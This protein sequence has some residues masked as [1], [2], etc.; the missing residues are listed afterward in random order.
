MAIT[1]TGSTLSVT[2]SNATDLELG[3]HLTWSAD[4][5]KD[6]GASGANRPR[7]GYFGTSV[8]SPLVT[9]AG[10]L[11]LSA[12]GANPITFSSGGTE[13]FRLAPTTR[14]LL[15]GT[16][17]DGNYRLDVQSS[18][19]SGTLRVYDQTAITGSTSL[20]VRAGAGQST[21]ELLKLQN[22]SG[23]D[24]LQAYNDGSG[25]RVN[26]KSPDLAVGLMAY[27]SNSATYLGAYSNHPV[28]FIAN[29]AEKFRLDGTG[30]GFFGVTPVARQTATDLATLLTAMQ[31]LGLIN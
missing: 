27:A 11:A 17:T 31:N 1:V 14:N 2:L 18:G 13:G 22:G 7:T 6:V 12:T 10:T 26:L 5:T 29:N 24:W 8:V 23:N 15:I 16:T 28:I 21:N 25:Y 3:G 20:V 19:S 4:N 30:I 9:N